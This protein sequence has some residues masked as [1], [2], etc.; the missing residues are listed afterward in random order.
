MDK[1]KAFLDKL[2]VDIT[3][4]GLDL[5]GKVID[6]IAYRTETPQEYEET[7]VMFNSLGEQLPESIIRER[8]IAVYKLRTPIKYKSWEIEAIELLEPAIGDK[9]KSGWEHIE[10]IDKDLNKLIKKYDILKWETSGMSRVNNPELTLRFSIDKAIRF[11]PISI[12]EAR[13]IQIETGT[14]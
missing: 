14:L 12:M 4:S 13:K 6:H 5:R 3:K 8:R 10:I 7:K 2:F 11:H 1:I 9:F